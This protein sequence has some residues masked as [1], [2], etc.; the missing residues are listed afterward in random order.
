MNT[1]IDFGIIDENQVRKMT[2]NLC[3]SLLGKESSIF[4]YGPISA[5]ENIS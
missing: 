4:T 1:F 3:Y 2:L 5:M